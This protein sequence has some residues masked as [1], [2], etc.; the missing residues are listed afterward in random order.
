[1]FDGGPLDRIASAQFTAENLRA[2]QDPAAEWL[3]A[4]PFSALWADLGMGK[5]VITLRMLYRLWGEFGFNRVLIVAPMRVAIHTWPAE[6]KLWSFA[7][8]M[9]Y[10]VVRWEVSE[11]PEMEAELAE[12][13][14]GMKRAGVP[15][16]Q[17]VRRANWLRTQLQ[18]HEK[19]KLAH[20]NTAV[21]LTN[22]DSVPWLVQVYG[23]EKWPYDVIIIDESKAV[24]N[25]A[26]NRFKA[27]SYILPSVKRLHELTA[28]PAPEGYQGLFSQTYLMDRGQRLGRNITSFRKKY[29][30]RHPYIQHK[31]IMKPGADQ[32]L[33]R[34]IHDIVYILKADDHFPPR[35]PVLISH[36]FEL[37]AAE[38]QIYNRLERNKVLELPDGREILP[39]EAGSVHQK[40]VQYA[41]GS[42]YDENR[43]VHW[44]HDHKIQELTEIVEAA[45][46]QPVLVAYWFGMNQR[47]L[48]EAF[49]Q[50]RFVDKRGDV[51]DDWNAGKVPILFIQPSSDAWGLN[52][53]HG[54]HILVFFDLIYPFGL[55]FQL[56]GRLRPTTNVHIVQVHHL[57]ALGTID[58]DIMANRENRQ[59]MQDALFARLRRIQRESGRG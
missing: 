7:A 4:N 8:G 32:Q 15:T 49:P 13:I 46:G 27:L 20:E 25:H 34:K 52:L 39:A 26:T 16:A 44:Y 56:I 54:G 31:W 41:S 11:H 50:A 51:L 28:S 35:K 9:S 57:V 19:W 14:E 12:A 42:V 6:L 24:D 58:E 5:C 29:M 59:A 3:L 18:R 36:K 48:K 53:H 21:H 30:L 10:T 23:Q 17:R 55:W 45:Q 40:L 43:A 2:Y 37:S 47:R 1:M 33:E 22:F 38:Q